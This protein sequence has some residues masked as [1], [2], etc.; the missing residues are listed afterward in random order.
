M[1]GIETVMHDGAGAGASAGGMPP[2]KDVGIAESA[3]GAPADGGRCGREEEES[4]PAPTLAF[5]A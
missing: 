4:P 2:T 3:D 5:D 1:P